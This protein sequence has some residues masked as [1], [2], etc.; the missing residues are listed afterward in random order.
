MGIASLL[1]VAG[2]VTCIFSPYLN[3]SL[4]LNIFP[5]LSHAKGASTFYGETVD[6]SQVSPTSVH[7]VVNSQGQDLIDIAANLGVNIIRITNG[8]RSFNNNEDSIYTADQWNQVLN[9]MQTKGIKAIILIEVASQNG[10][11]YNRDIQP[12]YL[13]LVQEY[14]GSGVFSNPDVYAVDLKNEPFLTDANVNM[15]QL[16]HTMIKAR[17]PDLKQTAGWW[18]TYFSL[19]ASH[20]DPN[21][22]NWGDASAGQ[23]L[24]NIVDFYSVHMYGLANPLPGIGVNPDLRTKVFLSQMEHG[25]Q[26]KKP[27]LIEEF[28]EANGDAVSDQNTIGSPQLQAYVYQ[29]V[30]QALKEMHSSQIIGTVAFLFCSHNQYPDAWAIVKNKGNYLFPAAYILQE[31]ALGKNNPSLHAKTVVNS[32]QLSG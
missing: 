25:L 32:E 31:Y 6:M 2:L 22:Y 23:K 15:L 7:Y 10:D 18:A 9:K 5:A 8:Q 28:G 27:I 19:N 3:F 13:N 21:N 1:V 29:A 17:Y 16:A 30:Y 24:D 26:T 12:V 20:T 4:V 14:I 11:Y